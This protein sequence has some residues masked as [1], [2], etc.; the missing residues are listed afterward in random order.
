MVLQ[1]WQTDDL[2]DLFRQNQT[3][4]TTHGAVVFR[5][6]LRVHELHG[7]V[8]I[9][10][11]A[12]HLELRR[13]VFRGQAVPAHA[14][15]QVL[16]KAGLHET[17]FV[18]IENHDVLRPNPGR[19][20]PGDRIQKYFRA[21]VRQR[22]PH[23]V[24]LDADD[25]TRPKEVAPSFLGCVGTGKLHQSAAHG[26]VDSRRI[27]DVVPGSSRCGQPR[28]LV[29]ETDLEGQRPMRLRP[30]ERRR[31]VVRPTARETPQPCFAPKIEGSAA[32]AAFHGIGI[33]S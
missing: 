1:D 27:F 17:D 11:V 5:V 10:I 25:V 9:A 20:Q 29:L 4:V 13:I 18:A 31:R 21:G 28:R 7:D 23:R 33:R 12:P 19:A 15:R 14:L 22:I 16:V 6:V 26:G 3:K 32:D 30:A 8:L 2:V 24:H